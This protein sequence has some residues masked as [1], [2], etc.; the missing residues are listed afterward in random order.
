MDQDYSGGEGLRLSGDM[1]YSNNRS[2]ATRP[3]VTLGAGLRWYQRL[4]IVEQL[5]SKSADSNEE[6]V[7][8]SYRAEYDFNDALTAYAAYGFRH[9]EEQ[10]HWQA[11]H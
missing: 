11:T 2:N 9:G 8:A 10:T 7:F 1:G 3:N 6:N 4:F 5:C